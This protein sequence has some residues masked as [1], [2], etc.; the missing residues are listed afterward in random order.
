LLLGTVKCSQPS[1]CAV[2][3]DTPTRATGSM[4]KRPTVCIPKLAHVSRPNIDGINPAGMFLNAI[5][6]R[7]ELHACMALQR[8]TINK[9][10]DL[11]IR[12][13]SDQGRG[14]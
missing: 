13:L 7:E 3:S 14:R 5:Q 11:C 2:R 6:T 12:M 4:R 8:N 9:S 1:F 10:K